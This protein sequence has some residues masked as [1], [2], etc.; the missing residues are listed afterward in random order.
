MHYRFQNFRFYT[1]IIGE[2][3]FRE[4]KYKLLQNPLNILKEEDTIKIKQM[5]SKYPQH[6][7]LSNLIEIYAYIQE[8]KLYIKDIITKDSKKSILNE[9][10]GTDKEIFAFWVN[11]AIR[12]EQKS[13]IEDIYKYIDVIYLIFENGKLVD[14]KHKIDRFKNILLKYIEE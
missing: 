2:I 14:E 12:L 9:L 1:Q 7:R 10:F 6:A 11:G 5:L 3:E 4:I 13:W 8:D